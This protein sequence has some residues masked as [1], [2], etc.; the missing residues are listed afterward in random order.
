MVLKHNYTPLPQQHNNNKNIRIAWFFS[1]FFNIHRSSPSSRRNRKN[2]RFN[3]MYMYIYINTY[4]GRFHRAI[5]SYMCF[6]N[7]YLSLRQ[8]FLLICSY[9]YYLTFYLFHINFLYF[10]I[11]QRHWIA[12]VSL[13]TSSENCVRQC[14]LCVFIVIISF[15]FFGSLYLCSIYCFCFPKTSVWRRLLHRPSPPT[16]GTWIYRISTEAGAGNVHCSA[17]RT[18]GFSYGSFFSIY[19]F[20][21]VFLCFVS[22][23]DDP[24]QCGW[25]SRG[26]CFVAKAYPLHV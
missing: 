1:V 18:P 15:S 5:K 9:C 11:I 26:P 13:Y 2:S 8:C 25:I 16:Q 20:F 6:I 17:S 12:V 3:T 4:K 14:M 10:I 23:H 22:R 24:A 21:F 19:I 7:I